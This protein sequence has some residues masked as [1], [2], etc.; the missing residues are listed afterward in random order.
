MGYT[1]DFTGS[2]KFNKPLTPEHYAF[3]KAFNHIRHMKR[4]VN[5]LTNESD[6]I[7]E[8]AGLPLGNDG[9]YF[10][11]LPED[12]SAG[13]GYGQDNSKGLLDTNTP[14]GQIAG[15]G[16]WNEN[17]RLVANGKAMPGLWCQWTVDKSL[18]GNEFTLEWDGGEKFYSYVEWLQ[19]V[20]NHFIAPW[21][22]WLNGQVNWQGED[23]GDIGMI[24]VKNNIITVVELNNNLDKS[25]TEIQPVPVKHPKQIQEKAKPKKVAGPKVSKKKVQYVYN[26][27]EKPFEQP[28]MAAQS[29]GISVKD[30]FRG[31]TLDE[32]IAK[33]W[34]AKGELYFYQQE[35]LIDTL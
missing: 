17:D 29:I 24:V 31:S 9:E 33:K 4:D 8:K 19:Y 12:I 3:L 21:G 20:I 1:T 35:P 34:D 32:E 13:W 25:E 2:F 16:N 10:I 5:Q 22:Y 27:F 18:D 11:G 14:P 30:R 28:T 15:F 7:R 23:S 6:P 26:L